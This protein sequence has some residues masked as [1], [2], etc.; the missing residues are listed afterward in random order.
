M[1]V[2]RVLKIRSLRNTVRQFLRLQRRRYG[3]DITFQPP[4]N[5]EAHAVATLKQYL[6]AFAYH[7]RASFNLVRHIFARVPELRNG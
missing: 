4:L 3:V 2:T 1:D 5:P 6:V 7:D